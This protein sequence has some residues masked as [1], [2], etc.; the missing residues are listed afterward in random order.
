MG[1]RVVG[2]GGLGWWGCVDYGG[3]GGGWLGSGARG[4]D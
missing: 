1:T 3:G 2:V 4:G